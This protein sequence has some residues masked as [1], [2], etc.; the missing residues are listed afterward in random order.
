MVERDLAA[1]L[2]FG[3]AS[4]GQKCVA[5]LVVVLHFESIV[6]M[7]FADLKKSRYQN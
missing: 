2:G 7:R 3:G 6:R 4:G 1:M 5:E